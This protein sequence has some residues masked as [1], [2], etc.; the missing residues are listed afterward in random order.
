[1]VI[2]LKLKFNQDFGYTGTYNPDDCF[3]D[4]D[5]DLGGDLDGDQGRPDRSGSRSTL[6]VTAG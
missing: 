2:V 1:M 3:F 6:V 4:Q 5:G